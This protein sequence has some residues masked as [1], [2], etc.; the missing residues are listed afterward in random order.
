MQVSLLVVDGADYSCYEPGAWKGLFSSSWF[1]HKHN[2]PGIRYEL[3]TCINTGDIV[4]FHGPFP[5]GSFP[6]IKIF[7]LALKRF[8]LASE[9]VWGD[10]GY[11]GDLKVIT[12]YH[13]FSKAHQKE[14]GIARARHETING[15][16]SDW[17]ALSQVYRHAL[18]KHHLIYS[19]IAVITQLEHVNGYSS[20][21]CTST[22]H[23]A[24]L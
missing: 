21:S 18:K 17:G 20:F 4:W 16:F 1:S 14:M 23:S 11:Q 6:D 10:R 15:R 24:I 12:P 2:G 13:P 19:S 7:R 22:T 3:A 9:R 8:L 5:C